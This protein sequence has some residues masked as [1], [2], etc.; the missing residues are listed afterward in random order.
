MIVLLL[1]LEGSVHGRLLLG[2]G[3]GR[4]SLAAVSVEAVGLV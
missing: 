1:Q 3:L 2:W 4:L